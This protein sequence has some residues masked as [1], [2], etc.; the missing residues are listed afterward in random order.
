MKKIL[1]FV[2]IMLFITDNFSF[3]EY[4][5]YCTVS[6]VGTIA[7]GT[8]PS[9]P[10]SM[11]TL[12]RFCVD[13]AL[14]SGFTA[15]IE[16]GTYTISGSYDLSAKDSLKYFIGVKSGV[17]TVSGKTGNQLVDSDYPSD[18][19][20]MPFINLVPG[21]RTIIFGDSTY[22]DNFVFI[23]DATA[24]ITVPQYGNVYN[25]Y[26]GNSSGT[27]GF[28]YGASV[29]AITAV[30]CVFFSRGGHGVNMNGANNFYYCNSRGCND[31]TYGYG[32][33]C[34]SASNFTGCVSNNNR[35]GIYLG[36]NNASS[37]VNCTVDD[38]TSY[39]VQITTGRRNRII[40]TILSS[41]GVGIHQDSNIKSTK[42][43][44]VLVYGNTINFE[45]IDTSG[46]VFRALSIRRG[47]PNYKNASSDSLQILSGSAAI[48]SAIGAR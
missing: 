30:N 7:D 45:N 14:S 12:L 21:S 43:N 38:N 5:R 47:N 6:G 11:D 13:S 34:Q 3:N 32:F 28:K 36:A 27:S 16:A 23:G 44:S 35:V 33:Y 31:A 15:I 42:V 25:C 20:E 18:S 40:N 22:I 37:V 39:G 24:P 19:F 29:T 2:F 48:D 8:T 4:W 9:T 10:M 46:C 26:F 1:L 17:L 41:N